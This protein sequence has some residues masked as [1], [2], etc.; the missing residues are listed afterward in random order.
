VHTHSLFF[1]ELGFCRFASSR[2]FGE[3]AAF[4]DGLY[5]CR[6]YSNN[7][8]TVR[9]FFRFM[10]IISDALKLGMPL[11]EWS[12]FTYLNYL[13]TMFCSVTIRNV[14]TVRKVA[15]RPYI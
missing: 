9:V 6:I 1:F 10:A 15:V 14:I 2:N 4:V 12:S 3:Y 5:F 11:F 13:K 7:T 8:V